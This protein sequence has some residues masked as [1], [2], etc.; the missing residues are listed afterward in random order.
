MPRQSVA[1]I[2]PTKN[3]AAFFRP[4]LE[5]IR[6]ADEVIVVDMAS[7]DGTQALCSEYDNVRVID[8]VDYIYANV[9]AGFDAAT[10]DWVIRLDSDEVLTPEL[11][12]EILAFLESPPANINTIRFLGRH[13][14]F[15]LPMS[16]GVGHPSRSMRNHMFR[17]GTAR[18]PCK[19]EH[20]DLDVTP[21]SMDFVH[22]YNH[23]TNHT[24]EE[25]VQKFNY[26]TQRDVERLTK[27]ERTAENPFKLIYQ[28][29]RLFVLYYVQWKGYRDG[30][31]GFYSSLFRG[32]IYLWIDRAKRWEVSRQE[33]LKK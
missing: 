29:L 11:Q 33:E 32:P 9:N 30:M 1:V 23:Y 8:K 13:H 22:P 16:W 17:K 25:V 18:Y 21:D 2:I 27:D 15:G 28:G 7:T 14:M 24:V 19:L 26:Y 3:V 6:F 12:N 4:T 5:S 31:L 20:E 10:T